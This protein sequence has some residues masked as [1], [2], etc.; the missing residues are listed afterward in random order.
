MRD[1]LDAYAAKLP[2]GGW[3][4]RYVAG[5]NWETQVRDITHDAST[6]W[7]NWTYRRQPI[8]VAINLLRHWP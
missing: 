3:L 1:A 6:S 4:Q 5:K 8:S 7:V 2:K